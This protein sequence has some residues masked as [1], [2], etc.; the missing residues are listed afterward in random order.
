MPTTDLN[1]EDCGSLPKPGP[2]GRLARLLFAI[3]ILYYLRG[4]WMIGT[5]LMT[6][7][8]QIQPLLWNGLLPGIFLVSY[9]INI[10]YSR[11][12]KKLPA[13]VSVFLLAS[14][15]TVGYLIESQIENSILAYTVYWW[16]FYLSMHLGLA[17][18]LS[19][20]IATPGCEMRAFHHLYSIISGKATKEHVCPV[21]PLGPIDRWE[22]RDRQL[23]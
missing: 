18:L 6:S 20:I 8:G 7:S 22:V 21:G 10:G 13:I 17:F 4:L 19:A 9:I 16:E 11:S 5:D 2:I 15:T 14:A 3:A 12:W 23:D 1:L